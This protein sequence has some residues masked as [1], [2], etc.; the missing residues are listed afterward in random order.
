MQTHGGL[1]KRYATPAGS[2]VVS[3]FT[4]GCRPRLFVFCPSGTIG[5]SARKRPLPGVF[6]LYD[7]AKTDA[8]TTLPAKIP[9]N[10]KNIKLL[11]EAYHSL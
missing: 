10:I 7:F 3:R 6:G 1:A 8:Q 11:R 2:N 5:S 9:A 4:V